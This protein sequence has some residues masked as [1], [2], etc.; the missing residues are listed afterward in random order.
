MNNNNYNED[1]EDNNNGNNNNG[2]NIEFNAITV[3]NLKKFTVNINKINIIIFIIN[4]KFNYILKIIVKTN[5]QI[6]I[7]YRTI[8]LDITAILDRVKN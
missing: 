3:L 1:N 8:Y 5:F 2:N 4:N 7:L 6:F